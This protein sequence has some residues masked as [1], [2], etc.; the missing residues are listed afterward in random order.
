MDFQYTTEQHAAI[1]SPARCLRIIAFAGTGKTTTLAGYALQRPDLRILYVCFNR[2]VEQAARQRFPLNVTCKTGHALAFPMMG[3]QYKHKLTGNLRLTEIARIIGSQHWETVRQ[4]QETLN[5]YLVSADDHI[6]IAHCPVAKSASA[7]HMRAAEQILSATRRLWAAMCDV[8]DTTAPQIHDG[9]FK[10]WALS[11]PDLS[12][13]FDVV[14]ADEAQDTNPVLAGVLA[15]WAN[16]G[17]GVVVCG[18]GHQ[19]LYRFR[20]AID[21]LNA[22]W[23]A[24]AETHYITQSFRFGPAIAHTANMLLRFKG[25]T[26]PLQ[27]MGA[28]TRVTRRLPPDIEHKAIL[29][30]TVVGV[31]EQALYHVA[32][33]DKAKIFWVG[34]INGYNLQDIE[35]LHA[36]MKGRPDRVKGKRLLTEYRDYAE[37]KQIAEESGDPEMQRSVKIVEQYRKNLPELFALLRK[38][39]ATDEL[40]AVVT[41]STAHK[42]KGL[43]WMAVEMAE[44]FSFEPFNIEKNTKEAWVDEMNLL[45]VCVTRAMEVLAVNSVVLEIMQEAK[46]RREGRKPDVPVFAD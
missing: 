15:H 33:N 36:F 34:G 20:G 31:I 28:N 6:G 22:P 37:Y 23:L 26:R 45:Y 38:R 13:R 30:R 2:S 9:Y 17:M 25:E 3:T 41:V 19:M 35:D 42:A 4:V 27:G 1:H 14:L 32:S 7:R 39:E 43:E 24:Q 16:L 12:R 29:C 5:N 44:D 18:D 40:D 21:A 11:R 10:L 46:D 8:N